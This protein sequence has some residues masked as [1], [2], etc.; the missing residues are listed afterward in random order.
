MSSMN[1]GMITKKRQTNM[2]N[3][4]QLN[5]LLNEGVVYDSKEFIGDL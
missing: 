3:M 5:N 2:V 4:K 1:S